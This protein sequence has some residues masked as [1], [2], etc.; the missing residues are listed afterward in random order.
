MKAEI[1]GVLFD[2][3]GKQ[4]GSALGPEAIR[5]AF[6]RN[7]RRDIRLMYR[8]NVAK[9]HEVRSE[10]LP[11]DRSGLKNFNQALAC[12]MEIQG[13]VT[14]VLD[15]GHTPIVLGG[16]HSIAI[17][18][19]PAAH[20][21]VQKLGG[22]LGVLWIDA[23][24]DVNDPRTSQTGNLHGMPI[25]AMVGRDYPDAPDGVK[26]HQWKRLIDNAMQGCGM[27]DDQFAWLGLRDVDLGEAKYIARSMPRSLPMSMETIDR[28]GLLS[29]FDRFTAWFKA[30]GCTHLWI[31]FD[32]DVLDPVLAP[33]TGTAVRGGLSYREGHL[34]AELLNEQFFGQLIGCDVV[35][36]NPILDSNNATV[37]VA[38]E[39]LAS[40]F[41]KKILPW[42]PRL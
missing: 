8:R 37:R 27:T 26:D 33:G 13:H 38:T 23:H 19:V 4:P 36:V 41:G 2:R 5:Y 30:S 28:N 25:A 35:E 18:S 15:R 42:G 7:E 39:W 22:K 9:W 10:P 14:G 40:L 34:L 29:A 1:V 11:E 3:C 17:G 6:E 16:D 31:S 32:V 12:Y 21:H 20:R 24:G